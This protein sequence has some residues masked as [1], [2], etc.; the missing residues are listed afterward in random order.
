MANMAATELAG[1]KAAHAA[2]ARINR[3]VASRVGWTSG[4]LGVISIRHCGQVIDGDL[5]GTNLLERR[6][7]AIRTALLAT[8]VT[9]HRDLHPDLLDEKLLHDAPGEPEQLL[10]VE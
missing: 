10:D 8:A 6:R 2:T 3:Q 1:Q 9:K 7:P 4:G 5:P